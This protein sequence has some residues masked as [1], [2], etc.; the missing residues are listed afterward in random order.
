MAIS[1]PARLKTK[2]N[3]A[4]GYDHTGMSSLLWCS[5]RTGDTVDL[6]GGLAQV[7]M[8]GKFSCV[9]EKV[10][11]VDALIQHDVEVGG[12]IVPVAQGLFF[13]AAPN[14]RAHVSGPLRVCTG[15]TG[16]SCASSSLLVLW[17][18]A[19][20]GAGWNRRGDGR[21]TRT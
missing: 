16:T 20:V 9:R 14:A 19:C 18:R 5:S 4:G 15:T 11:G 6:N 1:G 8:D 17:G 2:H 3:E 21:V 13:R 12:K 7:P 10:R